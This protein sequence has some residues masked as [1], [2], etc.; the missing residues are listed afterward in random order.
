M[1]LSKLM[2]RHYRTAALALMTAAFAGA[3]LAQDVNQLED[4]L[5]K[6]VADA[7][8]RAASGKTPAQGTSSIDGELAAFIAAANSAV[9]C[10]GAKP[11]FRQQNAVVMEKGALMLGYAQQL[12]SN[13]ALKA[14]AAPQI[15]PVMPQVVALARGLA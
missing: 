13:P 1:Q 14:Q 11:A 5:R 4:A 6:A 9:N 12:Q 7:K 8:A 15:A 10:S 2:A 3:T